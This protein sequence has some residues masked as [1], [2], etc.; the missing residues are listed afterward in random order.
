[1]IHRQRCA[2][3]GCHILVCV[4]WVPLLLFNAL[5]ADVWAFKRTLLKEKLGLGGNY[6]YCTAIRGSGCLPDFSA[7]KKTNKKHQKPG[8]SLK[9]ISIVLFVRFCFNRQGLYRRKVA[10]WTENS[11]FF[12]IWVSSDCITD[13]NSNAT[14]SQETSVDPHKGSQGY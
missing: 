7:D 6:P 5:G 9:E 2:R 11:F 4:K 14:V 13:K 10:K 12:R 1:M 3:M 8:H